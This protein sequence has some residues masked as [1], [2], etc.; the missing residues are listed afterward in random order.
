MFCAD[1]FF[2]LC[3][4]L[5]ACACACACGSGGPLSLV[6]VSFGESSAGIDY[7]EMQKMKKKVNTV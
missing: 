4:G 5:F 3:E 6:E 2:S 1:A 7:M